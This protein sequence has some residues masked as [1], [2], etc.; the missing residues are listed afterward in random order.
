MEDIIFRGFTKFLKENKFLYGDLVRVVL[1]GNIH[2]FIKEL[3][4]KRIE[5]DPETI[6]QYVK[7][8]DKNGKR[9]FENDILQRY[10]KSGEPYKGTKIVPS[11]DCVAV[12]GIVIIESV[13]IGNTHEGINPLFYPKKP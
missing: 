5:V 8:K 11:I 7:R 2:W 6:D 3:D 12:S 10:K 9:V 13:V 1:G 4:S